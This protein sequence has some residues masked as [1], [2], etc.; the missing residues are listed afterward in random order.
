[1]EVSV[2]PEAYINN[3]NHVSISNSNKAICCRKVLE[4]YKDLI[5]NNKD[6]CIFKL[7]YMNSL[8]ESYFT[9]YV[10]S[11]EFTAPDNSIFISN[12]NFE[13]LC[14]DLSNNNVQIELFNPP[15][16]SNI[17]FT[18]KKSL[19]DKIG[20]IKSNLEALLEKKYKFLE[21]NQKIDI[22]DSYILVKELIPYDVCLINN[23]DLNVE[24]DIIDDTLKE[25]VKYI[26]SDRET[27]LE[28][29]EEIVNTID[30]VEVPKLSIAEL[31]QKRLAY[32][33]KIL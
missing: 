29:K 23:T 33:S 30:D 16:A 6:G 7:G 5:L 18:I 19:L 4:K 24:F 21:K 31:R 22:L 20:D 32:Y 13:K 10:S 11:L 27:T 2:Y 15:Q 14:L 26:S 17:T 8:L 12:E 3:S 28:E 25:P 1:M 9:I